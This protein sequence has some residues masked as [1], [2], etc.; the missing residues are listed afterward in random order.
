MGILVSWVGCTIL[1]IAFVV[2]AWKQFRRR[3][4]LASS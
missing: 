4:A 3:S 1:A 2:W